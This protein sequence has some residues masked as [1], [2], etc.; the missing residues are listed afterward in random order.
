[1]SRVERFMAFEDGHGN[2]CMDPSSKGYWVRA[3]DFDSLSSQVEGLVEAL[4]IIAGN[5][6]LWQIGEGPHD[7]AQV[8]EDARA[9]AQAALTAFKGDQDA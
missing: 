6:Y 4:E 2:V 8:I 3:E 7:A 1:M 9:T 5:G